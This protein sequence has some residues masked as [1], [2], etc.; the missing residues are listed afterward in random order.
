MPKTMPETIRRLVL[1]TRPKQDAQE[2]ADIIKATGYDVQC[3]A[4]LRVVLHDVAHDLALDNLQQY[5]GLIFTS[6]NGVRSFCHNNPKRDFEV[7]AVGKATATMAREFGFQRVHVS[8]DGHVAS[9]QELLGKNRHNKLFY[10]R[11]KHITRALK[12]ENIDEL[13][14]YH[15]D[16]VEGIDPDVMLKMVQGAYSDIMLFSARTAE[17]FMCVLKDCDDLSAFK[18]T[19]CL[20]LSDSIA[21]VVSVL[22]WKKLEVAG[23]PNIKNIVDLLN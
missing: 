21:K 6:R 1:V 16:I 14:A 11:G 4:F 12:S 7:Y 5:E 9:L 18:R 13:I 20:C 22:R 8:Q 17:A 19:R 3:E 15:T 10:V 2:I 23:R